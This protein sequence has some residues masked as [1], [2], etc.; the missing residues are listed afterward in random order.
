MPPIASLQSLYDLLVDHLEEAY[1]VEM[2]TPAYAEAFG[3]HVN[4]G[5]R[6]REI[7]GQ[8]AAKTLGQLGL[9]TPADLGSMEA[10]LLALEAAA[11]AEG[12]PAKAAA[13]TA[14]AGTQAPAVSAQAPSAQQKPSKKS[15]PK[16]G[17]GTPQQTPAAPAKTVKRPIQ[18]RA[19]PVTFDIGDIA[20]TRRERR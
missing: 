14:P 9:P 2:K 11:R 13:R 17:A 20:P 7:F 12:T 5:L 10:R 16:V 15:R 8:L 19:A 18:R 3:A 1:Q 6:L 4:A